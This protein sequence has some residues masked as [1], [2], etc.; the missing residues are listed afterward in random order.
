[1]DIKK[2]DRIYWSIGFRDHAVNIIKEFKDA[3]RIYFMI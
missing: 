1:M 2:I 3:I